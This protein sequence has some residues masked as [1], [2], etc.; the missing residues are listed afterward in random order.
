MGSHTL[1]TEE[2]TNKIEVNRYVK[3]GS[4]IKNIDIRIKHV[5]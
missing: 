1:V 5:H 3:Y 4:D 2:Y